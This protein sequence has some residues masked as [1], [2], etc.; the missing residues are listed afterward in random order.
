MNVPSKNND[1]LFIALAFLHSDLQ[2]AR[3]LPTVSQNAGLTVA[4]KEKNPYYQSM[5]ISLRLRPIISGIG[6]PGPNTPLIK[7]RNM[8]TKN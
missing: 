2:K 7:S 4:P 3:N 8:S 1:S 6:N 5:F